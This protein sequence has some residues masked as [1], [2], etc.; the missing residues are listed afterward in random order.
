MSTSE[1]ELFETFVLK[2]H[3][4]CQGCIKKVRKVLRKIEGVYKVD[5]NSEEQKVIVTG[6]VNP[7]TLVQKLAK[8]GK[9]A[10]I[11]NAGYNQEQEQANHEAQYIMNDPSIS[12]N[13]YMI[14]TFFGKNHWGPEWCFNQDM[15]ARAMKSQINK[16]LAA[17][18]FLKNFNN[19]TDQN[20]TTFNE[21]P[22]WEESM[23]RPASF[24][25]NSGTNYSGLGSQE[26][27]RGASPIS[28]YDHQPSL[29]ANI[30]GYYHDYH[31]SKMTQLY[32][33]NHLPWGINIHMQETPTWNEMMM[34]AYMHQHMTN[35]MYLSLPFNFDSC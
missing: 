9:H 15:D 17:P 31:P 13:Q 20:F 16:H 28:E 32:S 23:M 3:M 25:Q 14:P 7:S 35:Q 1:Y 19:G 27:A 8:V 10:E 33:Y 30:H 2:V 22:E 18:S 21:N 12:E 24:Q 11:W 6:I 26:W 34:N 29:M 4:N 5:I